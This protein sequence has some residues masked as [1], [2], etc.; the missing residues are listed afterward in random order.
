MVLT[1]LCP[2]CQVPQKWGAMGLQTT[3]GLAFL[4]LWGPPCPLPHT[5]SPAFYTS[6]EPSVSLGASITPHKKPT[7]EFKPLSISSLPNEPS[8]TSPPAEGPKSF[9]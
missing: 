4:F 6:P 2:S 8:L 7:L 9:T 3:I 1:K 5:F